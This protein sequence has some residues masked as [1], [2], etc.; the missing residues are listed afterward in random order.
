LF[1]LLIAHCLRLPNKLKN[2]TADVLLK[3]NPRPPFQAAP[4][5]TPAGPSGV[6]QLLVWELSINGKAHEL[7]VAVLLLLGCWDVKATRSCRALRFWG[8]LTCSL[9]VLLLHQLLFMLSMA[10]APPIVLLD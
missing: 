7:L 8:G 10:C 9:R 2:E 6:V 1:E 4:Q 5:L 3:F